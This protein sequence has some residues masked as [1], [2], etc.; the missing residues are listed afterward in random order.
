MNLAGGLA[1][2]HPQGLVPECGISGLDKVMS[3][4]FPSFICYVGPKHLLPPLKGSWVNVCLWHLLLSSH[5]TGQF[6]LCWDRLTRYKCPY[7]SDMSMSQLPQQGA[8]GHN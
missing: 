4:S 8:H 7:P 5:T 6:L 1:C 2:P 3:G